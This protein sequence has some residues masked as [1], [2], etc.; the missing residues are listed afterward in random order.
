MYSGQNVNVAVMPIEGYNQEDGV[1]FSRGAVERGV[2]TSV[3]IHTYRVRSERNIQ[4]EVKMA[5]VGD[6]VS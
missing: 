3:H 4:V 1:V 2:L 5:K 6:K